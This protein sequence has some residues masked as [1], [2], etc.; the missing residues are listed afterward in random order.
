[1]DSHETIPGT[2][3]YGPGTFIDKKVLP[4]PVDARRVFA[5]LA[6]STPGFT[7][8]PRAWDTVSFSG[9]STPMI[10]GPIKAP[11]VAAALHGMC[12][13]V[14]NELVSPK[15]VTQ[16]RALRIWESISIQIRR[17]ESRLLQ[18]G[19]HIAGAALHIRRKSIP[20]QATTFRP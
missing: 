10:P 5:F 2:E 16:N 18:S 9:S 1:M 20:P 17:G 19:W 7:K 14:A 4:V 12:G 8:D 11:V 13:L 15:P 6:S 3:I